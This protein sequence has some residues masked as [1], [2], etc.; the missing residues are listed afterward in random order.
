MTQTQLDY[1]DRMFGTRDHNFR[2]GSVTIASGAGSL[3]AGTVIVID[4]ATGKYGKWDT[5]S[6]AA[7]TAL[8]A[9]VTTTETVIKTQDPETTAD[10]IKTVANGTPTTTAIDTT[11]K[12]GV[13]VLLE[14]ADATSADVTAHAGFTGGVMSD[15][16]VLA[17]TNVT[18]V[19][20]YVKAVLRSNGIEVQTGSS[21]L[22]VAGE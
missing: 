18:T 7:I 20:A 16:L 9:L 12:V 19:T 2:Y 6:V 5:S 11:K 21:S 4:P 15:K 17:G 1:N 8:A 13:A 14:A 22:Y 10:V 3:A